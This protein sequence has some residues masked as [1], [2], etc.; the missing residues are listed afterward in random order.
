MNRVAGRV[1]AGLVLLLVLLLDV[2]PAQSQVICSQAG[3]PSVPCDASGN[4]FQGCCLTSGVC[5]SFSC[6]SSVGAPDNARAICTGNCL[7]E[8]VCRPFNIEC[9]TDVD[10][11]QVCIG[12]VLCLTEGCDNRHAGEVCL[13]QPGRGR[14]EGARDLIKVCAGVF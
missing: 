7:E 3:Q 13:I 12:T 6:T 8:V 14:R 5:P 4:C 2:A 9:P 10:Q 1:L 11:D